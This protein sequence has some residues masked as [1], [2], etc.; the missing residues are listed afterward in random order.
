[1]SKLERKRNKGNPCAVL[2]G[3]QVGTVTMENKSPALHCMEISQKLKLELL[4][5]PA[6]LHLSIYQKK[7]KTEIRKET[8]TPCS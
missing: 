4:Y 5:D 6:V 2:V 1:L 8:C 3:T 7:T